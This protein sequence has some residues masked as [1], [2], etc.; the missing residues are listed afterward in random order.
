VT[1]QVRPEVALLG[2]GDADAG[3]DLQGLAA[4]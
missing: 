3:V 2:V 4:A 1:A